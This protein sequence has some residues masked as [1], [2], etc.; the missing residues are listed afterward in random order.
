MQI[1]LLKKQKFIIAIIGLTILFTFF[2]FSIINQGNKLKVVFFDVGQGSSIFIETPQKNQVLIDGGPDGLLILEQLSKEMPF[3][4]RHLDIVISTHSSA[5]HLTGLVEVL[6]RY[7]IDKIIWTGMNDNT[8][9]HQQ[10]IE[11]LRIVE[12]KEETKITIAQFGKKIYLEPDIY[13]KI[14]NPLVNLEGKNPE[15]HNN[16]SIVAR[17]NFNETSFLFTS[18]IEEERELLLVQKQANLEQNFLSADVLKIP[19][20]GSKTSSS[21]KFLQTVNPE[22]AIIQVGK[23]NRFGHPHK[24][25]IDRLNKKK[26]K[27]F[28]TDTQG[29]IKITSDGERYKIITKR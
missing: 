17:L 7:N 26:I 1:A 21:L 6:K 10:F 5:D 2:L 27:I 16:N 18:D 23:E 3:W 11:E 9:T 28:R 13:L 14:L 15:N 20:H 24:E 8:L 29:T 19:H 4:D 22:K 12:N 25:V